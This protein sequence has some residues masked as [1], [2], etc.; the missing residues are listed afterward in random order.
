MVRLLGAG[1]DQGGEFLGILLL[2]HTEATKLTLDT[3]EVAMVIGIA[4]YKAVS[5]NDLPPIYRS[6]KFIVN[7]LPE[8]PFH[9]IV[10][11]TG[12]GY[13]F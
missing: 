3:V 7:T 11:L 8:R 12:G 6:R 4:S 1:H 13:F 9:I 10:F 2:D 5:A